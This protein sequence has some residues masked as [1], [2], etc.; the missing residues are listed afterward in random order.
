MDRCI[1]LAAGQEIP[2]RERDTILDGYHYCWIAYHRPFK[3]LY[4]DGEDALNNETAKAMMA[5]KGT[6][7]RIRAPGQHA[8]S[9]ESRNGSLRGTLHMIEEELNRHN[10]PIVF[11]RVLAKGIFVTSAFTF[12][13]G[14]SPCKAHIGRQSSFLP[15]LDTLDF[16]KGPETSG[17]ERERRVRE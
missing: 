15:D 17:H 3:V 8:T 4:S 16:P 12:Y 9:I 10:I 13:N 2:D 11:P 7:L 5:N 14:V 1:R 6:T